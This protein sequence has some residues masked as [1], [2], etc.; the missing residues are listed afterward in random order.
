M[1]KS[2]S[3][4][5]C[6]VAL[7]SW[8]STPGWPP[9]ISFLNEWSLDVDLLHSQVVKGSS[10]SLFPLSP[11]L[12]L[13]VFS[14][15]IS[16]FS[17]AILFTLTGLFLLRCLYCCF[18]SFSSSLSY[19]FIGHSSAFLMPG[20]TPSP[21]P[22]PNDLLPP[23]PLLSSTH[24][25]L[26]SFAGSPNDSNH[27]SVTPRCD[28]VRACAIRSFVKGTSRHDPDLIHMLTLSQ[29][30]GRLIEQWCLRDRDRLTGRWMRQ[31]TSYRER[32]SERESIKRARMR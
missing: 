10:L 9:M 27:F 14:F 7:Q 13:T 28:C 32:E 30:P 18:C 3:T 12:H 24:S 17:V 1:L 2:W 26:L 15:H 22:A 25:A 16:I 8:D 4:Y 19:I 31:K 6:K 20:P 5:T 11:S 21:L 29:E 23:P